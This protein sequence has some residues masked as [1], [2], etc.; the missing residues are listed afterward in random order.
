M[1]SFSDDDCVVG[2][3]SLS[4]PGRAVMLTGAWQEVNGR[5]TNYRP[6]PLRV[7]TVFSVAQRYGLITALS[8]GAN[9]LRLFEPAVQRPVAY[10]KDPET[11]PFPVY[12]ASLR[13]R[14]IH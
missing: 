2:L 4:L 11:A 5:T 10:A 3:P 13:R 7:D 9:G 1:S 8:A 14:A 12:E 6:R